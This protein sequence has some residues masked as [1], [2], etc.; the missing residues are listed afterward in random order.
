MEITATISDE[1]QRI[2][3]SWLGIGQIQPWLQHALN[4]KLRRRIDASVL[5]H[6]DK[7]PK[8]IT[9][10]EKLLALKDVALP[11][12]EERDASTTEGK[13]KENVLLMANNR[14]GREH[15]RE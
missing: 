7:N 4:N 3:E 13:E 12:R 14:G 15:S 5:E 1:G 6:T 2:L 8:K 10:A 11:T 9:D